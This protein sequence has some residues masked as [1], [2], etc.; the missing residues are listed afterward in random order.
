MPGQISREDTG[1][2]SLCPRSHSGVLGRAGQAQGKGCKEDGDAGGAG[3]LHVQTVP[4][5][6]E[7]YCWQ[8][9][10]SPCL[11]SSA[12]RVMKIPLPW[13]PLSGLQMNVLVF[14]TRL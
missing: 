4:S 12:F 14:L 13:Q 1:E 2:L 3:R 6:F 10:C 11:M 9:I 7:M 5:T 8:I